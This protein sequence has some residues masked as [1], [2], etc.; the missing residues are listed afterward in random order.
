METEHELLR[1]QEGRLS[2][3]IDFATIRNPL[4]ASV[5]AREVNPE[6]R[7]TEGALREDLSRLWQVLPEQILLSRG[8]DAIIEQIPKALLLSGSR[9]VLPVPTYFGLLKSIPPDQVFPVRLSSETG[10]EYTGEV[11]H[12][13]LET[14]NRIRPG[15]VW[16]CS[17]NNPTG[18]VIPDWQIDQ[19]A[20]A[21]RPGMVVVDE[22]Y[23]EIVDPDNR[24][25]AMR[26]IGRYDNL[27]V[28][29]SF[30]KAY[31]LPEI[32]VGAAVASVEIIR[33]LKNCE[34]DE[35]SAHSLAVARAAVPD[36]EH[37]R[38]THRLI[39]EELA[40]VLDRIAGMDQIKVR[41]RS[42]SGVLILRHEADNLHERLLEQ[43]IKT[44][45]YNEQVG[46][47]GQQ[48]VRLGLLDHEQN[49]LLLRALD[50]CDR[51]RVSCLPE[52]MAEGR[53]VRIIDDELVAQ[54]HELMQ[55][56][57]MSAGGN[58]R[59][60]PAEDLW[61]LMRD[62]GQ[63]WGWLEAGRLLSVCTA[64]SAKGWWYLNNGVTALEARGRGLCGKLV[65]SVIENGVGDRANFVVIYVRRG[66]FERLG[67]S[68]V[69]VD[70][71]AVIDQDVAAMIAGKL[72]PGK[73]SHIFVKLGSEPAGDL[74]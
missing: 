16:L 10:F 7:S 33:A 12:T 62:G 22:A 31:G 70:A 34:I 51:R 21:A 4:G 66:L 8:S 45:D 23:Q 59:D 42:R 11:H 13:V 14:I 1:S 36:Q 44:I 29:R 35:P 47:E 19:I 49:F 38:R 58:L 43:G 61:K 63:L 28:T 52:R 3:A 73:E 71:L 26:F 30:S 50:A 37:L 69:T 6:A 54:A 67:F 48:F 25:S 57:F 68:E 24:S 41:A 27:V 15:L 60:K 56:E 40:W 5:A 46:L 2:A 55:K 18:V 64:E 9:V 72:R 17:P 39:D 74:C 53:A 20:A 65:E 32:R